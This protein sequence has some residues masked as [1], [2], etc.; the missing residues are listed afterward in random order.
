VSWVTVSR[1]DK[2]HSRWIELWR[3][4]RSETIVTATIHRFYADPALEVASDPDAI[5]FEGVLP[6]FPSD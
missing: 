1:F 6:M 3:V 5:R 2:A 4:A